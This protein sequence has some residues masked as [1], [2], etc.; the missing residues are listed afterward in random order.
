MTF[1]SYYR[2]RYYGKGECTVIIGKYEYIYKSCSYYH[3]LLLLQKDK[4][5]VLLIISEVETLKEEIRIYEFLEFVMHGVGRQRNFKGMSQSCGD[6]V[7]K[8]A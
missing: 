2:K 4:P 1:P 3:R 7:I 6:T 5:V 8:S